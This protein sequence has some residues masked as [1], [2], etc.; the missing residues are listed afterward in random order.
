M[1]GPY[2][3]YPP[4]QQPPAP[5]PGDGGSAIAVTTKFFPL[6]WFFYFIKPK[7]FV[8]GQLVAGAWGRNVIPVPPGQHQLSI[9]VPYFLPSEVGPAGMAVA[10]ASGQ[11]VELEYRAPVWAF[12]P[13]SLGIPPQQYN[14]MAAMIAVFAAV[15]ALVCVCCGLSVL[16]RL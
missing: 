1:T 10:V 8:N 3:Q 12:S 4:P 2:Q 6:A 13:G 9:H 16:V 15:L 7:I 14:G 11:I 5:Q